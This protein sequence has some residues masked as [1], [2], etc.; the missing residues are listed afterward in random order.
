[1]SAYWFSSSRA[2]FTSSIVVPACDV[3]ARIVC[4][5]LICVSYSSRPDFTGSKVRA[6]AKFLAELT[7]SLVKLAIVTPPTSSIVVNFLTTLSIPC[8]VSLKSSF[9]AEA[10]TSSSPLETP[11]RRSAAFNLSSVLNDWPTFLSNCWLSNR[12]STTLESTSLLI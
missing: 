12:I 3:F 7:A 2:A 5:A 1:M 6:F 11:S 8:T 10:L 9:L 4:T